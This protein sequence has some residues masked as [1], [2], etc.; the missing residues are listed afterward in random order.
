M[1]TRNQMSLDHILYLENR[2]NFEEDW[3]QKK[4]TDMLPR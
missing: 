4:L 3:Y 2:L 1:N